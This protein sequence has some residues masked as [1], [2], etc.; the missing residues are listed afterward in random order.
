MVLIIK[1]EPPYHRTSR[2]YTHKFISRWIEFLLRSFSMSKFLVLYNINSVR[3]NEIV[4]VRHRQRNNCC[5][6][7]NCIFQGTWVILWFI[8]LI[9]VAKFFVFCIYIV[10]VIFKLLFVFSSFLFWSNIF[11]H[12]LLSLWFVLFLW[13]TLNKRTH[14]EHVGFIRMF[15]SP[16]T[17]CRFTYDIIFKV[18]N[19]RWFDTFV[20]VEMS[21]ESECSSRLNS[22]VL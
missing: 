4:R 14:F 9:Y 10:G 8:W 11:C 2:D 1:Q 7:S 5:Q 16:I 19:W 3:G 6:I 12:L 17:A 22:S 13:L 20:D 15:A 18:L 21:N